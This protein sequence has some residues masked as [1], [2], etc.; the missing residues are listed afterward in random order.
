MS[1][2]EIQQAIEQLSPT[3]LTEFSAWFEEFQ[4]SLWDTQIEQDALAGRLDA[5]AA[6]AHQ[7]F[8]RAKQRGGKTSLRPFGL[9]AGEFT[10]PDDFDAPLPEESFTNTS[11]RT[12]LITIALEWQSR[13]GVAPSITTAL[14]E[15]D[16]AL[17]VGCLEPDYALQTQHRTAVTKDSDFLFAG[18]HYQIKGNRP[19]GKPGSKITKVPKAKNYNWD[20][21]IWMLYNEE[22][23]LLESWL[24]TASDYRARLHAIPHIRPSHMREGTSL[25]IDGKQNVAAI[26]SL[27]ENYSEISI[28]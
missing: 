26:E 4:A 17:L 11:L 14:S 16:A 15:Y 2:S 18:K 28:R 24:W 23:V 25:F 10:V 13:F 21:L 27:A 8:E 1:L 7:E 12:K 6:Q 3:E 9:S 22:Y 5:L 19:S 20:Y